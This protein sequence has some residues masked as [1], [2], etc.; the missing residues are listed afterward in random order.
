MDTC[1]LYKNLKNT[2][3]SRIPMYKIRIQLRHNICAYEGRY[4]SHDKKLIMV[5]KDCSNSW[6]ENDQRIKDIFSGHLTL[7]W[8]FT[9]TETEELERWSI[10]AP[11]G[12]WS[13]RLGKQ[14]VAAPALRANLVTHLLWTKVCF[15]ILL[16]HVAAY[17]THWVRGLG[18]T[19][20]SLQWDDVQLRKEGW[21]SEIMCKIK[22][23]NWCVWYDDFIVWFLN[24]KGV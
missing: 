3:I 23:E 7:W 11:L 24:R 15:R 9:F 16:Q 5:E 14:V 10:D 20:C 21:G 19:Q 2:S 4:L 12:W 17:W 18:V 13:P 6:T 1:F 22:W 8:V